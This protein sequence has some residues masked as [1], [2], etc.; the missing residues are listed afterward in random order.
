VHADEEGAHG[1]PHALE[2]SLPPLTGLILV[3]GRAGRPAS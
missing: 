1:R 3:P 2:L